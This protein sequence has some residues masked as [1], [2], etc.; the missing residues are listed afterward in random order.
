MC[1]FYNSQFDTYPADYKQFLSDYMLAQMDSFESGDMGAGWFFWTA[2]TEDHCAP[3][4][5]M[6]FLIQNGI[7][8]E[9]F[10][11]RNSYCQF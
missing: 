1:E 3:E 10:C 6:V 11:N 7:A 2:K 5:D 4:W 8:P 9:D